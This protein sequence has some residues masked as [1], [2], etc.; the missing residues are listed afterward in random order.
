MRRLAVVCALALVCVAPARAAGTESAPPVDSHAYVIEDAQTG[1]ILA[2]SNAH[3]RV[4]IASITKLMTVL[5]TL[6]HHKLTDVVTV[7]PRAAEVGEERIDLE[8]G[9]KITVH[10]LLEGALIQSGNDAADALALSM[11]PSYTAFAAMMNAKAAQLGLHDTHYVRADGLDA[12]GEYSSAYDVTK[13]ARIVMRNAF[14]RATVRKET[15]TLADG[16]VLHTW[17]DLL[18]ELPGT[19]GVK[20]GHTDNAGWCQVA[21]ARGDSGVAIY[22]TVLGSPSETQRDDDLRSLLIWGLAQFRVVPA[23]QTGRDYADVSLP[24]GRGSV[25]LVARSALLATVRL[26]QGISETVTAAARASLPVRAGTVLGKV[27]VRLHGRV[28]GSRSLVAARTINKPGLA[29][30]L[31]WYAGR[32]LHHLAHF[33]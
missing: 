30:R 6:E 11:A 33:I 4:A 1:E 12:P 21:A 22:A 16:E 17:N 31:G 9:Q 32:T 2:S 7:D 13:L 25:P 18:T 14:V 8:P 24:Y 15:A 3:A 23:V 19:F 20:T 26:G 10:D 5:L 28:L 27:V 29:R